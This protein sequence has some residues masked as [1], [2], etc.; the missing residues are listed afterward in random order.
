MS[1]LNSAFVT[2]LAGALAGAYAGARAA[3]KIAERSKM[4]DLAIAELRST[5]AAIMVSFSICSAALALKD[6]HVKPMYDRFLLEK[7]RLEVFQQQRA[8][9]QRQDAAPFEFEADLQ[10]FPAPVVPIKML[11]DLL[12]NKTSNHGRPLALVAVL[13]QSLAGL[14]DQIAKR[15]QIIANFSSGAVPSNV[16][17]HHYFGLPLED[18]STNRVFPDVVKGLREYVDDVVFFSKLLCE[19]LVAHGEGVKAASRRLFGKE[20]PH[21]NRPDFGTPRKN[22]LLPSDSNYQQWLNGFP[23]QLKTVKQIL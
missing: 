7:E 18:A 13:E 3:Q 8:T 15:D 4:R 2:S 21:V 9:R 1:F 6:Q 19:D 14:V 17:P 10:T 23:N 11:R 5:N 12:F 20:A 16:L 22:G